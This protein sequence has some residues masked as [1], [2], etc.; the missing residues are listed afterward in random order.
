VFVAKRDA[1][2]RPSCARQQDAR[3]NFRDLNTAG[4][5]KGEAC[6]SKSHSVLLEIATKSRN[7]QLGPGSGKYI[8][9]GSTVSSSA[10][11]G[12]FLQVPVCHRE[13]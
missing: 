12:F 3:L 9:K 4:K 8:R 1:Q 13:S 2:H 10:T 7:S 5:L 11:P 6:G